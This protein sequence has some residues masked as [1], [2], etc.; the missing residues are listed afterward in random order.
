MPYFFC[1][2]G[3]PAADYVE[4]E[5]SVADAVDGGGLLGELR[6]VVEGGAD[7]YHQL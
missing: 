6:G 5:A 1:F 2:V 4:G 7:G 3:P